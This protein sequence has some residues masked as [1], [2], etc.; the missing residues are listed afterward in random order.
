MWKTSSEANSFRLYC[1]YHFNQTILKNIIENKSKN[2]K[3]CNTKIC[4]LYSEDEQKTLAYNYLCNYN[5]LNDFNDKNNINIYKRINSDGDEIVSKTFIQCTKIKNITFTD[6]TII[7]YLDLCYKDVYYK[8]ELFEKPKEKD[9]TSVNNKES[10][11]GKNYKKSAFLISISFLL[12]DIISIN[13]LFLIEYLFLARIINII[14]YPEP[15]NQNKENMDTINSTIKNNQQNGNINNNNSEFKKEP[16]QTI[17]VDKEYKE[18]PD[19]GGD[20]NI[21]KRNKRLKNNDDNDLTKMTPKEEKKIQNL[22]GEGSSNL[23]LLDFLNNEKIDNINDNEKIIY[24]KV[25]NNNE[26]KKNINNRKIKFTNTGSFKPSQD[27][28][29]FQNSSSIDKSIRPMKLNLNR[30]S[31]EKSIKKQIKNDDIVINNNNNENIEDN[32]SSNR[33]NT[34]NIHGRQTQRI[35][36]SKMNLDNK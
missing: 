2:S 4:L 34:D 33:Y 11:P 35:I 20:E 3:I 16:T 25:N 30:I 9:F 36:L 17:I 6:E 32:N 27:K 10:C 28:T 15:R 5:S 14:Q 24:I 21:F 18:C 13:F 22:K 8:C 23:K 29:S 26:N 31:I 19:D 1:P 12:I 7:K